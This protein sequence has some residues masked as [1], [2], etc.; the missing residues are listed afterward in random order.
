MGP[1]H[2]LLQPAAAPILLPAQLAEELLQAPH[3]H[4]GGVGERPD[5]PSLQV[6]PLP[7]KVRPRT[8]WRILA[9][10]ALRK[11]PEEFLSPEFRGFLAAWAT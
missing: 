4:A 11:L 8:P 2:P 9:A 7:A 3:R 1:R 6:R 5:A 10:E